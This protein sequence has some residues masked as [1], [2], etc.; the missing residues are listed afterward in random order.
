MTGLTSFLGDGEGHFVENLPLFLKC[1]ITDDDFE[2]EPVHLRL[3][4]RIGPFLI[5]R[6]LGGEDQKR[7]R[8]GHGFTAQRHLPF[9]HGLEQRG[10][11]LGRSAVD[12]VRQHE[13]G[14]DRAFGRVIFAVLRSID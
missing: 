1:R 5:N 6:V 12:L 8:Q 14:K 10:L 11:H 3:R 4:Q 7:R 2:H 13:I 9:L